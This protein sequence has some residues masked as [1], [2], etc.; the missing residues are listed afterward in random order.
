MTVKQL[1][2]KLQSVEPDRLVVVSRDEEGN[3]FSKLWEI[4]TCAYAEGEIGLESLTTEDVQRGYTAE[5]VMTH[6]EKAV[7][8]WPSH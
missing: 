3:G 1:I 5:D 8:L 6:G 7:V 2:E 4:E